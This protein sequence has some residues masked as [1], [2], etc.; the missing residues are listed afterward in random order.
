M[1][2][3]KKIETEIKNN[4]LHTGGTK[5]RIVGKSEHDVGNDKAKNTTITRYEMIWTKTLDYCIENKHWESAMLFYREGCPSNPF[6][7]DEEVAINHMRYRTFEKG[8]ILKHYKSNE[9]VMGTNGK[10]IQC[11]GEWRSS[12]TVGLYRA[13]ISKV[14]NAYETT[15]GTYKKCCADC[16][17]I[18]IQRVRKGEGCS[19]HPGEPHYWPRGNV[20]TSQEFKKHINA[21][22]EYAEEHY[23]LR[24]TIALLPSQVRALRRYLLSSNR[25]DHLMLWVIIILGIKLFLRID[26]VLEMKYEQLL[27]QYFVVS[28]NDVESLLAKIKGK[29]DS[30]WLH[31][32]LWSDLDCPEFSPVAPLLIWISMTGIRG[33]YLF[34]TMEQLKKKKSVTTEYYPYDLCLADFKYLFVS[35]LR[36]DLDSDQYKN[37]IL[38][39]HWLRKTAFLFSSW[40]KASYP[41]WH[42]R[43][44]ETDQASIL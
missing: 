27:E 36:I 39:S 10:A 33:G 42:G 1:A 31:F 44:E 21:C 12:S 19:N 40:G 34:P 25:Q 13:A 16:A 6:P 35:V 37:L 18:P 15:Q 38:G 11:V 43:L 5:V 4:N 20:S 7:M 28:E 22:I 32:A 30:D 17:K 8:T 29:R 24:S 23:D 14:S 26:E 9:P 3:F 2:G 41:G